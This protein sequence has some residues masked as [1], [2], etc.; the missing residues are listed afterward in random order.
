[1]SA[2]RYIQ[3]D[4][5][6]LGEPVNHSGAKVI[7]PGGETRV[8]AAIGTFRKRGLGWWVRRQHVGQTHMRLTKAFGCSRSK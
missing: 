3:F 5:S 8:S 6:K 1:M 7:H 4:V 2:Y